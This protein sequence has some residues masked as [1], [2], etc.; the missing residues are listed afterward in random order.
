MFFSLFATQNQT[1]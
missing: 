1:R